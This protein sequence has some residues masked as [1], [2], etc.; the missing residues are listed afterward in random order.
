MMTRPV[1]VRVTDRATGMPLPTAQVIWN[2]S[3]RATTDQAG[4]ASLPASG[5]CCHRDLESLIVW[6]PQYRP[7]YLRILGGW[8]EGRDGTL[9]VQ[10][11]RLTPPEDGI[12]W[13]IRAVGAMAARHLAYECV[14]V[15]V[16][17]TGVDWWNPCL[18]VRGGFDAFRPGEP[19]QRRSR[20]ASSH[21]T[22]CAG[23][24]GGRRVA[25]QGIC[26]V[27]PGVP[28]YDLA[29]FDGQ[30]EDA[31]SAAIA[32]G[33][34]WAIQNGI[35]VLNIGIGSREPKPMEE[36]AY[37]EAW[38]AGVVL[39][40]PAGNSDDGRHEVMYPAQYPYTIAVTAIGLAEAITDE[41][42]RISHDGKYR[43]PDFNC[44]QRGIDLAAPGVEIYSVAPG[45]KRGETA[46][47]CCTGTSEAACF[48]TGAAAAVL[49]AHPGLTRDR[50]AQTP[51]T[52][53]RILRD[54]AIPLGFGEERE[55][56]GL[57][58]VVNAA[59]R[60]RD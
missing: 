12:G 13:G 57:V 47:D 30:A 45:V 7:Y 34:R 60:G 18:N 33:V 17:D 51:E 46:Y 4:I 58:N 35:Q 21:G 41:P 36:D 2:E 28:V 53:R 38:E 10:M 26:G 5:G 37:R 20:L 40:A 22:F 11:E 55:G 23:I 31:P 48:V 24:I 54:T 42:R 43:F 56:A 19:G 9:A 14:R 52:V 16:L 44:Y 6:H 25:Q 3:R 1:D 32:S 59:A 27:L 8:Q 50:G 39:V 29:V 49:A 15:A